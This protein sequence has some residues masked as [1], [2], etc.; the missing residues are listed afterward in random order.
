MHAFISNERIQKNVKELNKKFLVEIVGGGKN[1]GERERNIYREKKKETGIK[2][3]FV[4]M[5]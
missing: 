2:M 3:F 1:R 4:S 5:K